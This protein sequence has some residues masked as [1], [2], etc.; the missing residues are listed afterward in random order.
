M[1]DRV[2]PAPVADGFRDHITESIPARLQSLDVF[3]GGTIAAMILVNNN[4]SSAA[5]APLLHAKW[6]GWTFTDLVFPFFLWISGVAITLSFAKRLVR[7][8]SKSNLLMHVLKRSALIF[9]IGLFLNGFPSFDLSTIRI[10]G[11]LQRIAVCYLIAA[12]I[13][14]YTSTRGRILW[15]AGLL[16]VYWA[17]MKLA[18]VPGCATGSFEIDCNFAKW[19]DGLFLSG[20]MYSQTRTWDPEGIVSTLPAIATT[21]FGIFAGQILATRRSSEHKTSWLF[22]TGS[23]LLFT[24]LMLSTSMPINKQLWTTPYSIFTAGMAFI[25]FAS[26][27]WLID[28]QMWRRFAKPFA[29]YGMNALA[30]FVLS[31]IVARLLSVI[32]VDG[33]PLRALLWS[34]V[35]EPLASAANASLLFS[36]AHVFFFWAI[37][38]M[39]YRRN[40][41]VRV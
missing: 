2:Q 29:V 22:F 4:G 7:G 41:I 37:A 12:A 13:F 31:G 18:P 3:R 36:L 16:T 20:H 40:W 14:L 39:M 25:V 11:V 23:C 5:Y 30:M 17:L 10:P 33:V 8:D 26:C 19:V 27:H 15:T 35:F 24:G 34:N 28:V 6:H 21:L 32:K 9:L 1:L 38:W